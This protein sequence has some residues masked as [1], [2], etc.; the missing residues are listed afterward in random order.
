MD[1]LAGRVTT[2]R[3]LADWVAHL[4]P[5]AAVFRESQ[6]DWEHTHSLEIQR[7]A[8]LAIERVAMFT[9]KTAGFKID[10]PEIYYFPWEDDPDEAIKGDAM[11]VDEANDWLGWTAEMI[12]HLGG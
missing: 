12:E 6:P 9:G 4:P 2:L 1:A 10:E 5:E 7:R 11:D 8:L 3:D